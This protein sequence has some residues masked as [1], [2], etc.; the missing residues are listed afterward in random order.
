MSDLTITRLLPYAPLEVGDETVQTVDAKHVYD[1]LQVKSDYSHWITRAIRNYDFKEGRDFVGVKNDA[2]ELQAL[3]GGTIEISKIEYHITFDMAKELSML[4]RGERGK[5]ARTYFIAEEKKLRQVE[6]L[7]QGQLPRLR[8]P[9]CCECEE[10]VLPYDL[11]VPSCQESKLCFACVTRYYE[12]A[13]KKQQES[14]T[15]LPDTRQKHWKVIKEAVLPKSKRLYEQACLGSERAHEA[16]REAYKVRYETGTLTKSEQA[17]LRECRVT[18]H[19]EK[20]VSGLVAWKK[21]CRN[22]LLPK[23][24]GIVLTA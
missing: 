7:P 20:T 10:I 23:K 3:S 17:G 22:A 9:I 19:G 24:E 16:E 1:F 15:W 18:Y 11:T 12:E 21:H 6:R 2:R 8:D 14:G 4:A 13:P 5:E